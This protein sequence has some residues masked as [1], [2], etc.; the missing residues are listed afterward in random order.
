LGVGDRDDNTLGRVY[1]IASPYTG[2][3]TDTLLQGSQG[4]FTDLFQRTVV[5]DWGTADTGDAWSLPAG[6]EANFDVNGEAGTIVIGANASRDAHQPDAA[7]DTLGIMSL[8]FDTLATGATHSGT[9]KVRR[10]GTAFYGAR[11]RQLATNGNID[12]TLLASGTA[13][14][15]AVVVMRDAP[16]NTKFNVKFLCE[17][18]SPTTLKLKA[19]LDGDE[20]PEA[21]TIET[22]DSTAGV[23]I[24]GTV[25]LRAQSATG[26]TGG[27]TV[28]FYSVEIQNLSAVSGSDGK[29]PLGLANFRNATN[30]RV[31]LAAIE[32]YG[33]RRSVNGGAW[34]DVDTTLT[35]Q[36]EATSKYAAFDYMGGGVV[37]LW[38]RDV[39]IFYSLDYGVTWALWWSLTSPTDGTGF[40]AH[41]GDRLYVADATQV[42][43]IDDAASGTVT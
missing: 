41:D 32:E 23:Q 24:S 3:F 1:S 2:A 37:F 17:G 26:Y 11:L 28:Y 14:G 9:M 7:L 6:G 16:P 33:I 22:T 27:G 39:G 18:T 8:S 5:D 10:N 43:Y 19:W 20:E 38:D 34:A 29:R 13:V 42:R 25:G 12:L 21:W 30:Q 15:S 4:A 35:M 36:G 40:L 31:W